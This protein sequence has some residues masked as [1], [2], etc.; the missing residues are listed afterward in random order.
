[1]ERGQT[2]CHRTY[3]MERGQARDHTVWNEA[4]LVEQYVDF[5]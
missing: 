4:R 3:S 5:T 2:T 1:M